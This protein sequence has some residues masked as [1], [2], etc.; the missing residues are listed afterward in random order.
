MALKLEDLKEALDCIS[1]AIVVSDIMGKI[2]LINRATIE[3]LK[4]DKED[5]NN[6]TIFDFIPQGELWKLENARQRADSEY[7]EI[8]LRRK[9]GILLLQL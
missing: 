6:C 7:Y 2:V 5:E 9:M 4:L 1:E 8:V 3:K